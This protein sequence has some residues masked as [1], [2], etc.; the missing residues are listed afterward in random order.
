VAL[1]ESRL[2]QWAER[3]LRSYPCPPDRDEA[4]AIDGKT[5]RGS[6]KQGAAGTHLLSTLSHRL[7]LTLAQQAVDD[8]TNETFAIEDLLDGLMLKGRVVTVD[9]LNTQ[10]FIAQTIL[11]W[12]ADYVML[13]KDN[14]PEMLA[15]LRSC[16]KNW[17][18]WLTA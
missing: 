6:Q 13:V 3:V 5:L 8:K 11:D 7:G 16:S 9:A 17:R 18:W 1:F 12:E 14:H 10:R 15:K 4:I 2:R